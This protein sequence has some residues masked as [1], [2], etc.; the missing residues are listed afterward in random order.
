MF[1]LLESKYTINALL[2]RINSFLNITL[3]V[4]NINFIE[5]GK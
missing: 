3:I 5:T 1:I 4:F 2:D